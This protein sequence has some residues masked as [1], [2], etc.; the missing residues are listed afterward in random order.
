MPNLLDKIRHGL[1]AKINPPA[2]ISILQ[3]AQLEILLRIQPGFFAEC[4]NRAII[5][6]R[7]GVFPAFK[8]GHPVRNIDINSIDSRRGDLSNA[9]HVDILEK[10]STAML[11][12]R[13]NLAQC[14]SALRGHKLRASL[15]VLGLTMGVATLITVMTIVQGANLYV[16]QKIANLGTNVFQIARTPFAVTDFNIIIRA[17]KF[18]KLEL[19][20]MTAMAEGCGAC[21]EVG[22]SMSTSVR[23]RS[24][25]KELQDVNLYGQ[26]A[27]MADIDTRKTVIGRYFTSSEAEHRANVCLIGDTLMRELFLGVDPIGKSVRIGN[28]E[29]T[30]VGGM[31]KIG[32]VLGQD[33]DNFVIV[34]LPV[35][36][37]IQGIHSSITI[38][39]KTSTGNFEKAQDQAH[40]ILRSRRHQ[41]GVFCCIHHGER[42]LCGH[43][44]HRDHERHADEC[45]PSAE[46]D[47]RP[48][49]RWCNQARHP[50][51]VHCGK[52]HAMH[53]RRPRRHHPRIPGRVGAARVYAVPCFGTD[54]GGD[55]GSV[56]KFRGWTILRN[57][58]GSARVTA[59][60]CCRAE[61]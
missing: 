16:E 21:Q 39:V 47:W 22:A 32:S 44:W 11:A 57:L 18:K 34:P 59:G 28:D 58:S 9:L 19:E 20:D 27:N 6:T 23:A 55:D 46:R 24:G 13:D 35:F 1:D 3:V 43:R 50:A 53:C 10:S 4:L 52:R 42:D 17:L 40:L 41:L 26:T 37:R 31:E 33:Q 60:P 51:P 54:L 5:K 36:L 25:D 29:F 38:N 45:D 12:V 56:P 14:F 8:V 49:R 7:P 48:A 30:V 15:T 2:K 61:V